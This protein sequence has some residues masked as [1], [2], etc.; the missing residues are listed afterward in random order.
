MQPDQ[1]NPVG[2]TGLPIGQF[3]LGGAAFGN[4]SLSIMGGFS[5][6]SQMLDHDTAE[7]WDQ[8]L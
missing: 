6:A 3:G 7:L 8:M 1:R 5:V 2:K 4:I